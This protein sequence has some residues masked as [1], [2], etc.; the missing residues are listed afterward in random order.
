[1]TMLPTLLRQF[2]RSLQIKKIITNAPR[3]LY[4]LNSQ[5]V[6]VNNSEKK[7]GYYKDV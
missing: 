6:L 5:N 4:L 3:V 7:V 1:M 2:R